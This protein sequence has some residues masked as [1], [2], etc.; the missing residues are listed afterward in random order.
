M[1]GL[2]FWATDAWTDSNLPIFDS[3]SIEFMLSEWTREVN[4]DEVLFALGL[5][6]PPGSFPGVRA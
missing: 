1:Q 2:D 5:P 3:W 6:I 4:R